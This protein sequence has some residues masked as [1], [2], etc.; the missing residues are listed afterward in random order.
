MMRCQEDRSE[1]LGPDIRDC[2]TVGGGARVRLEVEHVAGRVALHSVL[3]R[4]HFAPG[5]VS[6]NGV[7]L[8]PHVAVPMRLSVPAGRARER[9]PGESQAALHRAMPRPRGGTDT[10]RSAGARKGTQAERVR[11]VEGDVEGSWGAAGGVRID[12]R[13]AFLNLGADCDWGLRGRSQVARGEIWK[14]GWRARG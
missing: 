1:R 7:A 10:G 6:L 13:R 11:R 3:N 9:T 2:R 8:H 12:A 5:R 4:L 14:G